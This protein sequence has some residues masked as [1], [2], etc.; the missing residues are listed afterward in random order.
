MSN[1]LLWQ[2]A[3][4]EL[5]FEPTFWPDFTTEKFVS[6]LKLFANRERRFGLTPEQTHILHKTPGGSSLQQNVM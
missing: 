5:F 2:L 6:L 1:F 4:A 3:Y